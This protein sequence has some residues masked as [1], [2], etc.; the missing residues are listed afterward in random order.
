[1][2]ASRFDV[3]LRSS[4]RQG[5]AFL[6]LLIVVVIILVLVVLGPMGQKAPM[7]G[8]VKETSQGI[9]Y[10]ERS[11]DVTCANNRQVMENEIIA[12]RIGGDG[13]LPDIAEMRRKFSQ[14]QCPRGGSLLI[15]TDGKVY[16]TKHFPPPI[17]QLRDMVT[18]FDE[19]KETPPPTP[20]PPPVI[21]PMH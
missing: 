14:Y 2:H 21:T 19:K 17:E 6:G 9:A 8:Q 10:I 13:R 11:A 15:G 18:L 16:C 3:A 4:R 5:W 7:Q 1:M 20:P 12:M